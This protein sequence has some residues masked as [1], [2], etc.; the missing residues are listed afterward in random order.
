MKNGVSIVIFLEKILRAQRELA[1][2]FL[3]LRLDLSDPLL[4]D[5]QFPAESLERQLISAADPIA[6]YENPPLA[7]V[8]PAE[9]PLHR[10]PVVEVVALGPVLVGAM[11]GGLEHLTCIQRLSVDF[12]RPL[13][14]RA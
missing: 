13:A 8:E 2:L 6:A 11:V 14:R 5:S 4:G 9:H 7:V 10:F 3:G 12:P 1:E